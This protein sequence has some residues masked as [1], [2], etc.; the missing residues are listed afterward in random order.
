MVSDPLIGDSERTRPW[1][2]ASRAV[3]TAPAPNRLKDLPSGRERP[4][5]AIERSVTSSTSRFRGALYTSRANQRQEPAMSTTSN[6]QQ[7]HLHPVDE[8]P[9]RAQDSSDQQADR[10]ECRWQLEW[11]RRNVED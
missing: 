8:A 9:V 7:P 5:I 10:E 3:C 4:R 1:S 11:A 2:G 6:I